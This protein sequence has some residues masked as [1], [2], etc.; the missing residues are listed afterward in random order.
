MILSAS[1][2]REIPMCALYFLTASLILFGKVEPQ[3]W[4]IFKPLGFIPMA[5][6]LAPKDLS[7]S[8]PA[9]YPAPFAQSITIL[10][11][12]RLKSLGKFF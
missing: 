8:G 4:L 7:N 6:T 12:L 11:P 3:F 9:L 5:I 2:S 1:P 10:K